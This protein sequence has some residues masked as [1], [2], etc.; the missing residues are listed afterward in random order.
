MRVAIV[1][2]GFIGDKRARAALATGCRITMVADIDRVRAED[3]AGRSG[4]DRV[5]S[6]WRDSIGASDIDIVVVAATHDN[7][8]PIALGAIEAGKHVLIEK[9]AARNASEL[10]SVIAAAER[11]G[12][13]LSVRVPHP[14]YSSL[15]VA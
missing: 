2:C 11:R 15:A 1:G 14:L 9:P 8:A 3:L 5:V 10:V 13:P 6:G 7:L 4:C 12:G